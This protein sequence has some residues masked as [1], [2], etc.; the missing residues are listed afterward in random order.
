MQKWEY[1]RIVVNMDERAVDDVTV[2][3][4]KVFDQDEQPKSKEVELSDIFARLGSEGW[5]LVN[6]WGS[7]SWEVF[8]FKRP[9]E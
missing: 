2:N 7:K 4:V 5:E 3:D 1:L 6:G 8:Y 9:V